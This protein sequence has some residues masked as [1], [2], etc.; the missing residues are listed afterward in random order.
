MAFPFI[1]R[2]VRCYAISRLIHL[3]IWAGWADGCFFFPRFSLFPEFIFGLLSSKKKYM[4]RCSM[5]C[6][7]GFNSILLSH[8]KSRMIF[9]IR[10]FSAREITRR[11]SSLIPLAICL[12]ILVYSPVFPFFFAL[13]RKKHKSER[14][15]LSWSSSFHFFWSVLLEFIFFC[16]DWSSIAVSLLTSA[17]CRSLESTQLLHFSVLP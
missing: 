5:D 7:G 17:T 3:E 8:S 11:H 4:E 6:F 13:S 9:T 16:R 15:S 14:S 10:I 1:V 2:K 12:S